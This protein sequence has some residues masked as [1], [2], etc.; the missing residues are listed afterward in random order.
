MVII[1][2]LLAG[3]VAISAL[4]GLFRG[5]LKE[6]LSLAAWVAAIWCAFTYSAPA[7]QLI[8]SFISDPVLRLWAARFLVLA[9][10]LLVGSLLSGLVSHLVSGT[11]LTGT[12]RT[13]GIAF[14]LARGAVL[15]GLAVVV[16]QLAGFDQAP[17]WRESKLIPYAAPVGAFLRE[18]ADDG[19]S[20][21]KESQG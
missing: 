2:Y 11:M 10:V 17:W 12:D 19:L 7:A 6:A 3:I 18:L 5:F 16:L 1:D 15:A 14:G 8:A 13:L 4:L 9:C 20:M 21:L